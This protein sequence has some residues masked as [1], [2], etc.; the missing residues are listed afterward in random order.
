M[1]LQQ[2]GGLT[3][4]EKLAL[5]EEPFFWDRESF[6]DFLIHAEATGVSDIVL[7]A[8]DPVIVRLDGRWIRA[9]ERI[10]DVSEVVAISDVITRSDSS[11]STIMGGLDLDFSYE[12][13]VD[14]R[15]R[16]RFRCNGTAFKHTKGEGISLTLRVIPDTPPSVQELGIEASLLEGAFPEKGLVLITGVMGSGKSTLLAALIREI[17]ETQQKNIITYES[18]IEFDLHSI[19][20]KQSVVQ[21]T[22]LPVHLNGGFGSAARNAARRAADV[23]L[24]GESRDPETLK[25]M[26]E[27]AEIGVCAYSTV[28]TRSVSETLTRIINVFPHEEQNQISSS[29]VSATSLIV[30]QR[31]L[32]SAS[33]TGRVA[34]REHLAFTQNMRRKLFKTRNEDFI[35]VIQEMV[36]M[37]GRSLLK[38]AQV[39]FEEGLILESD[40]LSIKKELEF[41]T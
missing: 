18:P 7:K 34:L 13:K 30:Q 17:A 25:S 28:H 33:G 36:E 12:I 40:F 39:K 16:K 31:L 4:Q 5:F 1:D 10:V 2:G 21:Q 29:L 8:S 6:D 35:S 32:P 37:E 3:P 27:S 9:T 22:E 38:D 15:T 26:V 11:S 24:I 14:K 41:S 23:I 20:N 19:K